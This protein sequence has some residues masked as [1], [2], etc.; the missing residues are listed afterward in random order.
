MKQFSRLAFFDFDGTLTDDEEF[1]YNRLWKYFGVPPQKDIVDFEKYKRGELT[2]EEWVA[3]DVVRFQEAGANRSHFEKATHGIA[4]MQGAR[5]T[6]RELKKRGYGIIVVSGGIDIAVGATYPDH[7]DLFDEIFINKYIFGE[8]GA[9]LDARATP[10]DQKHKATCI[11]DMCVRYGVDI[12][13]TIFTGDNVND[14]EAAQV[15]G[16]SFAFN[17][18]KQSLIDV[19]THHIKVKDLREILKYL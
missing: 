4:P 3:H 1:I 18:D 7:A 9:L 19:A 15:A 5:E 2:Y 6:L 10:Y 17:T 12:K 8:D 14:V 11:K 16:I 13:D